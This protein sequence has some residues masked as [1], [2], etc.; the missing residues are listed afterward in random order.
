MGRLRSEVNWRLNY[1]FIVIV[2]FI[3][4]ACSAIDDDSGMYI[5]LEPRLPMDVNGYFHLDLL[6]GAWQTTHRISGYISFDGEP[7]ENVRVE[8]SSSHFW[9]LNDTLGY[10]IEYGFTDQLEY[11]ALDT[12][13]ITG[14][15]EFVVP[16]INCCSYSNQYG[17]VNTMLAPVRSM[18]GDTM[19]V[20][21]QF[22]DEEPIGEIYIVLD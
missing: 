16:V 19:T 5:E 17:V 11:L 14:F 8:W 1:I 12:T 6:K 10:Y 7:A 21:I 15:D 9:R 22:S 13:Y 18:S 20:G 4:V 2:V 3:A